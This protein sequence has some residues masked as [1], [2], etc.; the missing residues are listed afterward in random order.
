MKA[1]IL[2]GGFAKRLGLLT[3]PKP[4]LN[5]GGK[6]I[7]QYII[8][9]IEK[10]EDIDTIYISTNKRFEYE[11]GKWLSGLSN[12][13]KI[14][15]IVEPAFSEKEKLGSVGG[16]NFS[17]MSE[18]IKDDILVV[19]GDNLFKSSLNEILEFFKS[20]NAV[21]N[22]LYDVKSLDI[23]K[24]Q[25]SV[26][27]DKNN[28]IIELEEKAEKP[29]STMISLGIYFFPKRILKLISLYI[30]EGNDP[31]KIGN[32][33]R[34][35]LKREDIFGFVFHEKWFDIGWPESL[36]RARKEFS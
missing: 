17:I 30:K 27:T 26:I 18:K 29:K 36:E 25:G 4:L 6:P 14:K 8:E 31:D 22:A 2:A 28:K 35:L 12:R 10:L 15:L 23:A 33:I 16:L 19:N 24:E 3:K 21:V 34:W 20:K 7:V 11:F 1:I 13:N 9:K 32:F 5:V